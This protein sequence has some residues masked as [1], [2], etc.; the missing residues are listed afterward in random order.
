MRRIV[1]C[2]AIV[3]SLAV[4]DV[5]AQAPAAP[6]T[7][8]T[9]DAC[10]EALKTGQLRF[11]EPKFFGLATR[12]PVD[13]RSRIVVPLESDVCLEML[14]VGGRRFVAQREGTLFRAHRL[15]D[16]SLSLYARDDCGNPVYGLVYPP[17][18]LPVVDEEL[19]E[20]LIVPEREAGPVEPLRRQYRVSPV[21]KK[22]KGGFCSS[23]AC[24]LTVLAVGGAA[25]GYAAW[26]YWPC[27]PGTVRR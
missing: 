1:L 14:V 6:N 5:Q 24:R 11:Y 22:K 12:N 3:W 16:G 13:N 7:F 25:A 23:T 15:A 10:S 26:R 19:R 9:L 27:P 17:P 2:G 8:A 21:V 20:P 18:V 4:G